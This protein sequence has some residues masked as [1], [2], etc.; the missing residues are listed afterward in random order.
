MPHFLTRN[1]IGAG[2]IVLSMAGT[3]Y[4]LPGCGRIRINAPGIGEG[5]FEPSPRTAPSTVPAPGSPGQ[6]ITSPSFPGR[7]II[8]FDTDGD[9]LIDTAFDPATQTW[10]R[11]KAIPRG[12]G[13][14]GPISSAMTAVGMTSSIGDGGGE[15]E[16]PPPDPDVTVDYVLDQCVLNASPLDWSAATAEEFLAERGLDAPS[17]QTVNSPGLLYTHSFDSEGSAEVTLFWST[18]H[19]VV[20][21]RTFSLCYAMHGLPSATLGN[22][23]G[24]QIRVNGTWQNVSRWMLAMGVKQFSM[25]VSGSTYTM[26]AVSNTTSVS[27]SV[28]GIYTSTVQ[29]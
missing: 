2:L 28:N 14:G 25:N 12:P 13:G 18:N 20:D 24:L 1:V 21:P 17:G 3:I 22:A 7:Q 19:A 15:G 23:A 11:L 10:Y 8:G 6:Q 9:G 4:G 16:L 27:V 5:E 29:L 26:T